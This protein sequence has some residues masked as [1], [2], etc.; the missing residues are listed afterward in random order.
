MLKLDGLVIELMKWS[1]DFIKE[2]VKNQ[3]CAKFWE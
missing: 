3:N 1:I 2:N